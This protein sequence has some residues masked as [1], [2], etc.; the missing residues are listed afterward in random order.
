MKQYLKG[1]SLKPNKRSENF[2]PATLLLINPEL[3]GP[4]LSFFCFPSFLLSPI[5]SFFF[6]YFPL[7]FFPSDRRSNS[8]PSRLSGW[9]PYIIVLIALQDDC[10]PWLGNVQ[11]ENEGT[12]PGSGALTLEQSALSSGRDDQS[13]LNNVH[14]VPG[15][16]LRVSLLD[17]ELKL[18]FLPDVKGAAFSQ[19]LES[20]QLEIIKSCRPVCW[21]EFAG[22]LIST[23]KLFCGHLKGK[24]QQDAF[25]TLPHK[26]WEKVWLGIAAPEENFTSSQ[27]NS[28]MVLRYSGLAPLR[29]TEQ[30]FQ[31]HPSLVNSFMAVLLASYTWRWHCIT[32]TTCESVSYKYFL[33]PTG[34]ELNFSCG[35][36]LCLDE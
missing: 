11:R 26:A 36:F 18:R 17:L 33:N 25:Q 34:T 5:L 4:I 3:Y 31:A 14:L 30:L 8:F 24:P 20:F 29:H 16:F 9:C 32:R 15:S 7:S 21:Q 12:E 22:V 23:C 28:S 27:P 35:H 13:L 19:Y 10:E 6:I 2:L 1:F